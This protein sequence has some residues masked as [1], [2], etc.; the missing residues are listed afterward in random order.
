MKSKHQQKDISTHNI[1]SKQ[2]RGGEFL[3]K[4][5]LSRILLDTQLRMSL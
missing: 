1:E 3:V 4:I 2:R 5:T